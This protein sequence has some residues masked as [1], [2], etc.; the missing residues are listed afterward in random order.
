MIRGR[1]FMCGERAGRYAG[2]CQSA[3]DLST[4]HRPDGHLSRDCVAAALMRSTRH[5]GEQPH[6]CL[7]DLAPGEVYPA[8]PITRAPGGLLHHRFTL[9]PPPEGDV[10]RSEERR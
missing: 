10:A 4:L 8:S 7:S 6:R 3:P 2:F 9:T 5:L 1:F